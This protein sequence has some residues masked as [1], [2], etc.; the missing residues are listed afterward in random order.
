[1][2]CDGVI[3]ANDMGPF[4][5]AMNDPTA[6]QQQ[7]PNCDIA[8]ADDSGVGPPTRGERDLFG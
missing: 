5:L 4:D 3:D 7:Y 1:M 2:N 6:Y 8:Q